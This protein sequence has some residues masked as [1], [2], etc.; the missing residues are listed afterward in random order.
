MSLSSRM[1]IV[2]TSVGLIS[3]GFLAGVG[4]LTKDRIALNKKMEIERAIVSVVPGS[5]SGETLYEEKDFTVYGAKN[6][7]GDLQGFALYTSGVGF[8]D[9]ISLMVG[10]DA[11]LLRLN[12]IAVLDQKETPGL[13]AKI[14][15]PTSFLVFWENKD[16]TQPLSL[17]KPPAATAESL[18]ASE[19][20]TITGA[21][22]SS[23]AVLGIV[24]AAREK[25]KALR[26]EGKLAPGGTDAD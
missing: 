3:G 22:I 18:S 16:F 25:L 11:S 15:D 20:N 14:T 24:N 12:S 2:L 17:R 21:T 1:I 4:I 13:G 7:A 8:Q 10:V 23:E 19:V 6:E 5:V 9:K 26:E